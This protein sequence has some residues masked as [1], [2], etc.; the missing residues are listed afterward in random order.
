MTA[1]DIPTLDEAKLEA[2]VG[3]AVV[4]M[5]AAISGLLLH[6]GDRLGLY[7]A[8]AGAGPMTS[9]DPGAAKRHRRAVRAR[10]AR[11]SGRRRLRRLRSGGNTYVLPAE[12]AMVLADEDSPVFL[13]GAFET[14]ASCYADHDVFID[15]FRSGAGIGW[16]AH[17]ERLFSGVRAALPPRLRRPSGRELAPGARTGWST[18]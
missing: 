6:M 15:A 18:S 8:M 4:D 11:Q 14:I 7:K 10:V 2:F 5:G 12:H 1:T 9:A 13:G 3:Q 17:D 16:H